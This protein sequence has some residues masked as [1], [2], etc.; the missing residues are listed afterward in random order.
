VHHTASTIRAIK[1]LLGIEDRGRAV[2]VKITTHLF[3]HREARPMLDELLTPPRYEI[4]FQDQNKT[5]QMDLVTEISLHSG[6]RGLVEVGGD[7]ARPNDKERPTN[8]SEVD[9]QG[10]RI[11]IE[12]TLE[13]E[14][15]KVV[16]AVEFR[17]PVDRDS[18]HWMVRQDPPAGELA[19]TAT[20]FQVLIPRGQTAVF[21]VSE[22]PDG[23]H[24]AVA[25]TASSYNLGTQRMDTPF[26]SPG[27]DIPSEGGDAPR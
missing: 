23:P 11:P 16:G 21:S 13:G 14:I 3:E 9:W 1:E 4:W 2:M 5:K 19:T 20:D 25:V 12:A 22:S 18:T 6:Q 26:E 15:V 24:F 17:L 10:V 7:T 8:A 27:P